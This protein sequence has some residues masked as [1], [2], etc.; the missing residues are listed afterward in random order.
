VGNGK[1]S[2]IFGLASTLGSQEAFPGYY[3]FHITDST[4]FGMDIMLSGY[5][6]KIWM[7][8]SLGVPVGRF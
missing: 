2:N 4:G 6:G 1:V 5:E 3:K 8:T 7:N